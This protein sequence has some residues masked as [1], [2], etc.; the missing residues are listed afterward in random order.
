MKSIYDVEKSMPYLAIVQFPNAQGD[1]VTQ[2]V[3]GSFQVLEDCI[4]Y[5][6]NYLVYQYYKTLIQIYDGKRQRVVGNYNCD[7]YSLE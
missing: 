3:S 5:V 2:F 1:V 6:E 7:D 4:G